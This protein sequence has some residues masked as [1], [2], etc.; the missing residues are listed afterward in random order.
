MIKLP[1]YASLP[2][3]PFVAAGKTGALGLFAML[4]AMSLAHA[5]VFSGESATGT[6]VLSYLQTQ[7]TPTLV[8]N[9]PP[10]PPLNAGPLSVAPST[11]VVTAP[12]GRKVPILPEHY[13]KLILKVAAEQRVSAPLIAA[14]AAAESGFDAR[15]LSPKGAAGMMQLMPGTARRFRVTDRMSAEQSVR[16]GAAYLRWL[17]EHFGADLERVIAAYN[18]GEA[19]V[20]R[21]GGTPPFAETQ[22]YLPRVLGFVQHFTRLFGQVPA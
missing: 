9:A 4:S 14:V 1:H 7:E 11:Q 22:A 15:A 12:F 10:E 17:S 16:G 3:T 20:E 6:V 19:A 21:A 5:Q 2:R 8:V 13:R 18:A